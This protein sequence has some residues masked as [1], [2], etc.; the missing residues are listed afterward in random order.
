MQW[1][2]WRQYFEQ[3]RARARPIIDDLLEIPPRLR[4]P[5]AASLA[6][7][8]LGETGEGRIVGDLRRRARAWGLCPDYLEAL[9]LFIGEEG[10]HAAIL[11]TAVRALGGRTQRHTWTAD[12]FARVRRLAGPGAELLVL[13]AAEVAA[14][15]IYGAFVQQL[16]AGALRDALDQ[17]VHDEAVHLRFH[18]TFLRDA[19]PSPRRRYAVATA[20]SGL[21]L[22]AGLVVVADHGTTLRRL[23]TTRRA[24]LHTTATLVAETVAAITDRRPAT[25]RASRACA[26]WHGPLP[27]PRP[28]A[29]S[30]RAH[31][32]DA[33]PEPGVRP[34][35]ATP[36]PPSPRSRAACAPAASAA[37]TAPRRARSRAACT[38]R[39]PAAPPPGPGPDRRAPCRSRRPAG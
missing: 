16:P 18:V 17:I 26:A 28:I 10:R 3:R 8:Q 5:L 22:A 11:G 14:L 38:A 25:G 37:G 21:G 6:R 7:F 4:A 36:R 27:L 39:G 32:A 9:R 12:A 13:L 35:P 24:V 1:T 31:P 33:Q 15:S 23:G 34:Q 19:L 29:R 2:H 30:S 20:W